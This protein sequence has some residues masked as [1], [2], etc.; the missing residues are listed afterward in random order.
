MF[1][2][3]RGIPRVFLPMHG[4]SPVGGDVG[5]DLKEADLQAVAVAA[6]EVREGAG[7]GRVVGFEVGAVEGVERIEPAAAVKEPVAGGPA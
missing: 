1:A 7:E 6:C 4:A 3:R 2:M 5:E